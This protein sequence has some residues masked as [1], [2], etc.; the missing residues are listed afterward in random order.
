MEPIEVMR[1]YISAMRARDLEAA[2]DHYADD[3]VAYVPGRS[4]LAGTLRG[5]PAVVAYLRASIARG[6]EDV[7]VEIIDT[8]VGHY[9]V[10]LL[11]HE[12]LGSGSDALD[13]RR[14]NVYRIRDDKIVEIRIFEADQYAVDAWFS[15]PAPEQSPH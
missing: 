1:S 15:A 10:A 8:L 13:I 2:F 11:V 3:I 4:A 14:A 6:R 5:R 12:R 7:S 9:H